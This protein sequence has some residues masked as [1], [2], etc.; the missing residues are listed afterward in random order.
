MKTETPTQEQFQIVI[1]NLE[2]V[3]RSA[4]RKHKDAPVD[5]METSINY[6]GSP[7]CFAGWYAVAKKLDEY[8]SKYSDGAKIIAIDLGFNDKSYLRKWAESN[9]LLWGNSFGNDM[10]CDGR[11]FN[12][13]EDTGFSLQT[14]INHWKCVKER[15]AKLW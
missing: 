14:I 8:D 1:D 4:K 6:C 15:S 7:M 11:A 2:K 5:M 9:P 12:Q 3:N 10:F 13:P